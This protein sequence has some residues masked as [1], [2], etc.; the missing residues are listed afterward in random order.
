[1]GLTKKIQC[2]SLLF[3]G[4]AWDTHKVLEFCLAAETLPAGA[5]KHKKKRKDY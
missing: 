5:E 2:R 3:N 4:P 1:M